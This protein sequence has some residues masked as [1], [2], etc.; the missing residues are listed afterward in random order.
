[1]SLLYSGD[2]LAQ[3]EVDNFE[4]AKGYYGDSSAGIFMDIVFR[5]K[6]VTPEAVIVYSDKGIGR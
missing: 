3:A 4:V 5:R 2:F 6:F 1:M